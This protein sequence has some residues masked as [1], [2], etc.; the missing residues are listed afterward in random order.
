MCVCVGHI[1]F[2]LMEVQNLQNGMTARGRRAVNYVMVLRVFS[3]INKINIF[4]RCVLCAR[5]CEWVWMVACFLHIHTYAKLCEFQTNSILLTL[6]LMSSSFVDIFRPQKKKK[7][8]NRSVNDLPRYQFINTVAEINVFVSFQ[9][10]ETN[11][12]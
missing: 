9:M 11:I 6:L 2:I 8:N 4:I 1:Y 10:T 12:R 7:R 5:V 3:Y